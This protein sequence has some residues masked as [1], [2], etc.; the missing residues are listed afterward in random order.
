M[1]GLAVAAALVLLAY[2]LQV[3]RRFLPHI[4][5]IFQEKPL[6]VIPRGQPVEDAEDVRLTTA[7]GLALRGCYLRTRAPQRRGVI[8][9]GLEYGSNRWACVPYT[10]FLRDA[11][12][13]VFTF[14]PRSQGDS[15]AQPGYEPMQWVTSY[16][17]ADFQT[18]IA[19]LKGRP[20]A[21]PRGVGF[22]GISKGGSAGLI[23]AAREPLLRCFVT[24][25]IFATHTTMLPYMRKWVTIYS[26]RKWIQTL[27]PDWMYS[28]FAKATLRRVRRETGLRFPHLER[29][30][31]L[32]APRPLLMIHGGG[33]TYI[34]PEMARALFD[35]A[36][37]PREL[38]IVD[39]AKHNQALHVANGE[40]QRRIL[41]FFQRCLGEGAP[42]AQP[43]APARTE[44]QSLPARLEL[45]A[46]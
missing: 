33:D 36:G 10:Q 14:E 5:R 41:E 1:I 6:F 8:F 28:V 11:G 40:Y 21:D 43:S 24:D 18:A 26:N 22:F 13:D 12:F 44:A 35:L 16:E 27:L 46:R 19:Y 39:G 15:D 37:D 23:A 42:A 25:G 29:A 9:F 7:E 31:P 32:L 38:W 2:Y 4:V 45:V 30:M 34:K 20:D 3:K 17:V